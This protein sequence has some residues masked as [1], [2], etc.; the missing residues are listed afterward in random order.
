LFKDLEPNKPAM[1]VTV[2]RAKTLPRDEKNWQLEMDGNESVLYEFS[3]PNN[4]AQSEL[5][6]HIEL[7]QSK[8]VIC[9]DEMKLNISKEIG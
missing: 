2:Y 4:W 7:T 5:E 1:A 3:I 9:I 6:L 8:Q